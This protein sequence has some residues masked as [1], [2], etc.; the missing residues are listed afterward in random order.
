MGQQSTQ[1]DA[2]EIRVFVQDELRSRS[3]VLHYTG[4][5]KE[6]VFSFALAVVSRGMLIDAWLLL[7]GCF[8]AKYYTRSRD[9][10]PRRE[11]QS[12]ILMGRYRD[13]L[14]R[15][16]KVVMERGK[17][18]RGALAAVTGLDRARAGVGD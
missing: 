2:A 8:D 4:R 5:G 11:R 16:R 13:W 3:M 7:H 14:R 1:S 12:P 6:C 15:E 17:G 10:R 9:A 18:D